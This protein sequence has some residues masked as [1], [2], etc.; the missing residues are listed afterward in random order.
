MN[1]ITK[2]LFI[3]LLSLVLCWI[4]VKAD[5]LKPEIRS[6]LDKGDTTTAKKALE[7]EIQVDGAY[8]MNY[9]QLGEIFF[10]E[11]NICKRI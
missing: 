1:K 11:L 6:L 8:H 10:V 4:V 9:F 7:A 3:G 2:S 5:D